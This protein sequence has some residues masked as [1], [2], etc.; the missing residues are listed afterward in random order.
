MRLLTQ[1]KQDKTRERW[2]VEAIDPFRQGVFKR[3]GYK[4][5]ELRI[6]I[7]LPHGRGSIKAI[8]QCWPARSSKD[9]MPSIFISPR[10]DS[11]ALILE[12]IAH[13]LIHAH[14]D[15]R[16]GHHGPFKRIALEIGLTGPMKSTIAGPELRTEIEI[17]EKKLG[18]IPHSKLFLDKNPIKKQKTRMVKMEC[19]V[20]NY[21]ARSA[22]KHILEKGAVICPCN[23]RPMKFELPKES[24]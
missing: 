11:T 5:P 24:E 21:I 2:L 23:R 10:I 8:G 15:C 1:M 6:S 18:Q 20:C 9:K 14:L 16:H 22:F 13:E 19:G 7:G 3:L 4:I 17:M 12:V